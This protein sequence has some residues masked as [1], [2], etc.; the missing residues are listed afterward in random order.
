[1]IYSSAQG[2]R[3]PKHL[4]SLMT[5]EISASI[6]EEETC[7]YES[8]CRHALGLAQVAARTMG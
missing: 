2:Q 3:L 8:I 4:K 7:K 6:P 1:M 5:V